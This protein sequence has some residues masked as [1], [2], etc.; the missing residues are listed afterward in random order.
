MHRG[1]DISAAGATLAEGV[2]VCI[3]TGNLSQRTETFVRAHLDG[4]FGGRTVAVAQRVAEPGDAGNRP[5]MLHPHRTPL[6]RLAEAMGAGN[7]LHRRFR[8]FAARHRI[9]F[10]LAEFGWAGTELHQVAW[11]LGIP[12]FCYFRGSDASRDLRDEPYRRRLARMFGTIDG[13]VTV[14][15]SLRDGLAAHGLSHPRALVLPSGVDTTRFVPAAKDPDLVLS[16]GRLVPKKAPL[17]TIDAF[18]IA[19]RSRPGLR[20]EII[21][22]GELEAACRARIAEHGLGERVRLLGGR[23]HDFVAARMSAAAIYTQHSVTAADGNT[24]GAPTAIQEAMAAETAIIATRH[25]GIP[26]IVHDGQTGLLVDEHDTAAQGAALLRLTAD[27][28]ERGRLALAARRFALAELDVTRLHARL[29][30]AIVEVVELRRAT[31][32]RRAVR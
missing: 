10:I 17:A 11:E 8:R 26:E 15:A 21:G 6:R 20:L 14:A 27:D 31:S 18:S 23:D 9:G 4:L 19:A 22:E 30:R 2:T 1:V 13:I 12:M 24:E 28:G 16:V 32:G 3:A 7:P 5:V 29:E 25:A